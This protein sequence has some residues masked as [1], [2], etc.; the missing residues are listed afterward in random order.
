MG[1]R[2]FF[3]NV[4]EWIGNLAFAVLLWS[5]RKTADE[6]YDMQEL[7]AA[8]LPNEP[9]L[10]IQAASVCPECFAPQVVTHEKN[11][12]HYEAPLS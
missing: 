1:K 3:D 7:N 8:H 2:S 11:C 12:S 9:R 10:D 4:R 6:Y 5:L